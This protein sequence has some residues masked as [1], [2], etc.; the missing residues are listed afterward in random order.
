MLALPAN[1]PGDGWNRAL[2][3]AA[4]VA[5]PTQPRMWAIEEISTRNSGFTSSVFMQ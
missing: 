3:Y 2:A 1:G 5:L 4:A